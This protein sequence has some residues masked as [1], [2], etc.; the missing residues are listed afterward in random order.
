MIMDSLSLDSPYLEEMFL[1]EHEENTASDDESDKEAHAN[2]SY[3]DRFSSSE[4]EEDS[5]P[6]CIE[7]IRKTVL[8]H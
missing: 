7:S 6:I 3:V 5:I 1:F 4:D 8:P 2:E